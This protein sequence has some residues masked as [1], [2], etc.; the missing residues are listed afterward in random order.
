MSNSSVK[1]Q[2]VRVARVMDR[3]NVGGPAKHAVFTS[4]LNADEFEVT[5]ISGTV[6]AGEGDMTYLARE[7]GI[8]PLIIKEMSR[9]IS[10]LDVL[11]IGKLFRRFLRLKPQIVHTH[12]AKAGTVGRLAAFLYKWLTPAALIFKPR[13]CSVV[14][15][16]HG[17]I[18]HSYFSP[19]KT[20]VFI[21]IERLL[22]RFFT[23]KIIVI[24]DEQRR[25]I[26]DDFRIGRPEQFL[27]MPLG[28]D[29][30]DPEPQNHTWRE[31]QGI[32]ADEFTIGIVGRLCEV[33]NH[34]MLFKA[35]RILLD[36]FEHAEK[37]SPRV[38]LVVIGD[39]ELRGELE[40]LARELR[41]TDQ[42]VFTG[43]C[44]NVLALY[45]HLDLIALTSLNEGTPVTLIEGMA[46]A[47]PIIST[48]VGGV[49]DLMGKPGATKEGFTLW[50]HGL[51]TASRDAESFARAL[52]FLITQPELRNEMGEAA[53]KFALEKYSK[54]R[55]VGDIETLYHELLEKPQR[56]KV[57]QSEI[58]SQ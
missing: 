46:F 20:R 31:E 49:V 13:K 22:A 32:A 42:V 51:T 57:Q 35:F 12:K 23:D 9:A 27:V 24:S 43:F 41:L 30:Q 29:F 7:A 19:A 44:K 10:P 6:P 17:H 40:S 5:L 47:R 56:L 25:E 15:T 37:T 8:E 34:A 58:V 53:Q 36:E 16:F 3:L 28:V 2:P 38:R 33:K 18:F 39:G 50:A 4:K 26:C 52:H 21:A 11:V 45:K 14:H 54:K 48:A 55:L 1:D